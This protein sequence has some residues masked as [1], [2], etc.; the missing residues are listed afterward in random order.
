MGIIGVITYS[1]LE[2]EVKREHIILNIHETSLNEFPLITEKVKIN[3]NI[4]SKLLGIDDSVN[5]AIRELYRCYS[6]LF[7]ESFFDEMVKEII[8]NLIFFEEE[9]Y[10]NQRKYNIGNH[11]IEMAAGIHY[12]ISDPANQIEAGSHIKLLERDLTPTLFH[13]LGHQMHFYSCY[14]KITPYQYNEYDPIMREVMAITAGKIMGD[15]HYNRNP[16]WKAERIVS[17]RKEPEKQFHKEWK[18]LLQ[19]RN[20][21]ELYHYTTTRVQ[22]IRDR[23]ELTEDRKNQFKDFFKL[24]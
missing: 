13:E 8:C 10:F 18:F 21:E 9:S 22:R 5:R 23:L 1:E 24:G 17:R 15:P 16:H 19:F 3:K 14:F 6:P 7:N 12:N 20:H 2:Q 11:K 4:D